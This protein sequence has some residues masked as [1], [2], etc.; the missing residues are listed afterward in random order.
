M[1]VKDQYEG[2]P[3]EACD[4]AKKVL[5]DLGACKI[6]GGG[7]AGSIICLVHNSKLDEFVKVMSEKYTSSNVKIVNIIGR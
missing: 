1:M 2:S 3:L 6:N 7:F 5:G 4:L